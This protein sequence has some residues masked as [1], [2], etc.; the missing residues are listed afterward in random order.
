VLLLQLEQIVEISDPLDH[1]SNVR[2]VW[3]ESQLILISRCGLS[4]ITRNTQQCIQNLPLFLKPDRKKE[5][6]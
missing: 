2:I 4:L 6:R 1:N 3:S 5:N